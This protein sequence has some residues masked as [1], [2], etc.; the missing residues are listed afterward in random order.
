MDCDNEQ[1]L[2]FNFRS[3]PQQDAFYETEH[4]GDS[5]SLEVSKQACLSEVYGRRSEDSHVELTF[6]RK[7]YI[8]GSII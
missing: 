8:T 3:Y 7:M 1:L 6:P 5:G 2:P 4:G